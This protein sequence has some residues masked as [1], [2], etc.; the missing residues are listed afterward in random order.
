MTNNKTVRKRRITLHDSVSPL[1][2]K[3][4]SQISMYQQINQTFLQCRK[5]GV[6]KLLKTNSDLSLWS[7]CKTASSS[8][9]FR[10]FSDCSSKMA[11]VNTTQTLSSPA[12]K[13]NSRAVAKKCIFDNRF[14]PNNGAYLISFDS[15]LCFLSFTLHKLHNEAFPVSFGHGQPLGG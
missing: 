11:C 10:Y 8:M 4:R 7:I 14:E 15:I 2:V 5:A 3:F 6:V 12:Y 9:V 13:K 1:H